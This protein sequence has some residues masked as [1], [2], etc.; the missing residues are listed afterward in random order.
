MTKTEFDEIFTECV[1]MRDSQVPDFSG[2]CDENGR[3]DLATALEAY[4]QASVEL[5]SRFTYTLLT[6]ILHFDE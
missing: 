2:Y 6:K 3:M 1:K 5:N 4:H